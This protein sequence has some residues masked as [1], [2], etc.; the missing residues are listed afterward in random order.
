MFALVTALMCMELL[1]WA[2]A[3]R[4]ALL[5][6]LIAALA[7]IFDMVPFL[8]ELA[9]LAVLETV[10]MSLVAPMEVDLIPFVLAREGIR[11]A[12]LPVPQ[13]RIRAWAI[14]IL[15]ATWAL[16]LCFLGPRRLQLKAKSELAYAV[17]R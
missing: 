9:A 14:G 16:R 3:C 2:T 5:L 13:A 15:K 7:S 17:V 11:L 10:R 4:S 1:D 12:L 6:V 8:V